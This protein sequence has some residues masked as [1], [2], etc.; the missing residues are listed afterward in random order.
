MLKIALSVL[1]GLAAGA[2]AADVTY[3]WETIDAKITTGQIIGA[4]VVSDAAWR[5]GSVDLFNVPRRFDGSGTWDPENPY[6]GNPDS[7][8]RSVTFYMD[9]GGGN[10]GT[11]FYLDYINNDGDNG[12]GQA[13]RVSA[14][15]G[16]FLIGSISNSG[17][18][19][20]IE[21]GGDTSLWTI[22]NLYAEGNWTNPHCW[23]GRLCG[24][25]TGRWVLDRSTI[26]VPEPSTSALAAVALAGLLAQRRRRQGS[27]I[28]VDSA[29][30]ARP[31][32]LWGSA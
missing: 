13:S 31:A 19:A 25:E 6:H 24:G 32:R 11:G 16:E 30:I 7:P 18:D 15:L 3:R 2:A 1:L 17:S 4:V 5:A 23:S 12:D 27:L 21:M 20:Y 14:L 8:V 28:S 10:W 22:G 26:P 9:M 29:L